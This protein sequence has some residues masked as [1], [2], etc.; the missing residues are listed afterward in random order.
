[1]DDHASPKSKWSQ[2]QAGFSWDDLIKRLPLASE[3]IPIGH[4]VNLVWHVVII[5]PFRVHVEASNSIDGLSHKPAPNKFA[6]LFH[7]VRI[8]KNLVVV[9]QNHNLGTGLAQGVGAGEAD[10]ATAAKAD[11]WAAILVVDEDAVSVSQVATEVPR[12]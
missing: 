11:V 7:E 8:I 9:Y 4:P 10:D 1:M 3:P 2:L 5:A 12:E 6:S